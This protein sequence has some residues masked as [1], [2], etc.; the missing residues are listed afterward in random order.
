MVLVF[1]ITYRPSNSSDVDK[2]G[3][4]FDTGASNVFWFSPFEAQEHWKPPGPARR[5]RARLRRAVSA[6][7]DESHPTMNRASDA[8]EGTDTSTL[9]LPETKH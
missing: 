2:V 3:R 7:G 5:A 9:T 8:N 6:A 4:T 1:V